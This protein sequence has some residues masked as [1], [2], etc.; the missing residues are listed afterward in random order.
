MLY[1]LFLKLMHDGDLFCI[2][3]REREKKAFTDIYF[4]SDA[5]ECLEQWLEHR[6]VSHLSFGSEPWHIQST[7]NGNKREVSITSICRRCILIHLV[8]SREPDGELL[9]R[10]PPNEH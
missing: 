8:V 9:P 6:S 2:R 1:W 7:T 4:H 10:V 5:N 3:E